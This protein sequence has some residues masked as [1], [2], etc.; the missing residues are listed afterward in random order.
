MDLYLGGHVRQYYI[1]THQILIISN[2]SDYQA[3]TVSLSDFLG[4]TQELH[5]IYAIG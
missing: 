3:N 1:T 2:K 4:R 5:R